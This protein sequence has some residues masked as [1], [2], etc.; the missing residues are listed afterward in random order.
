MGRIF[1]KS[2]GNIS[3]EIL[4]EKAYEHYWWELKPS[5]RKIVETWLMDPDRSQRSI[6]I[7]YGK[8]DNAIRL[9][10]VDLVRLGI[11]RRF[12]RDS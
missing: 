1:H 2:W 4:D 10:I 5:T 3:Y 8:N 6:E 12:K 9:K 7:E 11:I